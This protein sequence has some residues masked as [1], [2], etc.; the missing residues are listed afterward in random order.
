MAIWEP[1]KKQVQK[2]CIDARHR[3][4]WKNY[5]DTKKG[6]SVAK[7][8]LHTCNRKTLPAW[9]WQ[10]QRYDITQSFQRIGPLLESNPLCLSMQLL[11]DQGPG[12]N[13]HNEAQPNGKYIT[14]QMLFIKDK[15]KTDMPLIRHTV[16][17]IRWWH[18][19]KHYNR[20]NQAY[21]NCR[22]N[23]SNLITLVIFQPQAVLG[24]L[25]LPNEW[26]YYKQWS[27]FYVPKQ[28]LVKWKQQCYG[29]YWISYSKLPFLQVRLEHTKKQEEWAL[30]T[31]MATTT[32][33]CHMAYQT[34]D[35]LNICKTITNQPI[36][37]YKI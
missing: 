23:N 14:S 21:S 1:L 3:T 16:L 32:K 8:P 6:F 15:D 9:K 20:K 34:F 27:G 33:S 17:V 18:C 19:Q 2:A 4:S 24:W 29:Y 25:V 37:I 7:F 26:F 22:A 30:Y 10:G 28:N 11:I 35:C 31:K 12:Q 13:C 36:T 5:S